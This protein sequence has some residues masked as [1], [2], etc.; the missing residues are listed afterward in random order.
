LGTVESKTS[1]HKG[2]INEED[3]EKELGYSLPK[4]SD[5]ELKDIEKYIKKIF[6]EKCKL[7]NESIPKNIVEDIIKEIKEKYGFPFSPMPNKCPEKPDPYKALP[8]EYYDIIIGNIVNNLVLSRQ[9][10]SPEEISNRFD[11]CVFK[12]EGIKMDEKKRSDFLKLYGHYLNEHLP[13]LTP[14][15]SIQQQFKQPIKLIQC[16]EKNC[17]R[18]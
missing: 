8:S 16:D 5:D 6:D 11:S 10:S 18:K 13:L 17:L 7:A 15:S 3:L 4:L 12:N 9:P 1:K 2:G 14:P